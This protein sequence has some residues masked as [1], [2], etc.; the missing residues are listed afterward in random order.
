MSLRN[1][2]GENLRKIS[3]SI[4]HFS[5]SRFVEFIGGFFKNISREV[6]K[7][8]PQKMVTLP[9]KISKKSSKKDNGGGD[10][11]ICNPDDDRVYLNRTYLVYFSNFVGNDYIVDLKGAGLKAAKRFV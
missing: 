7:V 11:E 3:I 6:I 9:L 4:F 8:N 1:I 5:F 2:L 10:G